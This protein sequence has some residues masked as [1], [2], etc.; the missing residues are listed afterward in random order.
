MKNKNKPLSTSTI[1][2]QRSLRPDLTPV[3][4]NRDHLRML[5]DL[6]KLDHDL[7]SS[8]LEALAM[9]LALDGLDESASFGPI[10]TIAHRQVSTI[11]FAYISK[12]PDRY[13]A[14]IFASF[15]I[16]WEKLPVA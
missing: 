6:T 3:L 7:R 13:N 1:H 4:R 15:I 2:L 14:P 12:P 10:D 9:S 16:Y 5:E 11:G 8:G